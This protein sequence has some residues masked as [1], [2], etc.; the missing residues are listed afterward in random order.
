R[1]RYLDAGLLAF[2]FLFFI[3]VLWV[4]AT[5]QSLATLPPFLVTRLD[6]VAGYSESMMTGAS[7]PRDAQLATLFV[8]YGIT[9]LGG[10]IYLTSK[11]R[12]ALTLAWALPIVP[13]LLAYKN[14]FVRYAGRGDMV[15][16]FLLFSVVYYIYLL[17]VRIPEEARGRTEPGWGDQLRHTMI[18]V[19][20]FL[21]V[22]AMSFQ[23]WKIQIN[24]DFFVLHR[25]FDR[26]SYNQIMDR[27]YI[28]DLYNLDP[29]FAA[30]LTPGLTT[31]IIPRDI[32]LLF[33]Y[34]LPWRPRPVIQSY[35]SY[36]AALDDLDAGYLRGPDAPQQIVYS[37]S[38]IDGRNGVF[39]T[40]STFRAILDHYRFD[41]ASADGRYALLV[42]DPGAPDRQW[43]WA[44]AERARLGEEI[45]IPRAP[46]A[47]VFMTAD[48]QLTPLGKL[49][50]LVYKPSQLTV[51]IKL[52][53]RDAVDFRLIRSTA[54]NGLFVSNHIGTLGELREVLDERY[55]QD[56][57]WVRVLGSRWIYSDRIT[58]NFYELPFD[59]Q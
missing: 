7:N 49:M 31:D 4:A 41:A 21:V 34:D 37:L 20:G 28:R 16:P 6:L 17:E 40:P 35:Q 57:T 11:R 36:T 59:G 54:A 56:I 47:H 39:D 38:S 30:R 27:Q 32:A 51:Q 55:D 10:L 2:T 52:Q 19:L 3:V 33:A 23:G 9:L 43:N 22:S 50:T 8:L 46:G 12:P 53:G 58:V 14:I 15:L 48:V 24:N 5:G 1:R 25:L 45:R 44:Q 13:L 42:R 29:A 18:P 26:N